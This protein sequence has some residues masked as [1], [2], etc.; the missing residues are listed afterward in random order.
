M[1]MEAV[2]VWVECSGQRTA[3]PADFVGSLARAGVV[4]DESA[5]AERRGPG[6]VVFDACTPGLVERLQE[7]SRG[8]DER[9]LAVAASAA[10]LANRAA[11][12]IRKAGAS[13]VFAWDHSADPAGEIAARFTRWAEVDAAVRSPIVQGNLV[14]RSPAW[15]SL[16]RQI[17][18]VAMF[19]DSSVLVM[20]ESG[21]G[22]E[23]IARL[24]HS[25]DRRPRRGDLVILDCT[26]ITPGLSESEFYGHEKGAFTGAAAT[27]DGAFALA[28]SGTLFLDEVGELPL[29]LQPQLLRVIQEGTYKRV[30]G[31]SWLRTRFRLVCAT[32][33]DLVG[34]LVRGGFRRDLYHRIASW[35]CRVPPLR[36]RPEDI[37]PLVTHFLSQLRAGEPVEI[38]D[39]VRE[40]LV[41]RSYPGNV[42]DL[43]QLVQR[44]HHR[45][46]GTG[47]ITVGDIPDDELPAGDEPQDLPSLAFEGCVR[48]ALACGVGLKEIG[49][50]AHETAVRLAIADAGGNLQRAARQLGVTDR[51]LQ[52]R[53]RAGGG[54][55]LAGV[56]G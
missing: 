16:L 28:D 53:R 20:G 40:Y 52:L 3:L 1:G 30:G 36:E 13:D 10:A 33:R 56:E 44:I 23:L 48:R 22:K 47:P 27:R 4:V 37:L 38:D 26:T 24:V 17:V 43:R 9:V 15:V 12:Q 46:V 29:A 50:L 34:E 25:L 8:G 39:P 21:T 51:A 18:E 54:D 35:I 11:W 41:R 2:R 55:A 14:G 32:N 19:T 42:R 49:R 5:S 45:H 31:N 6:L 7:V